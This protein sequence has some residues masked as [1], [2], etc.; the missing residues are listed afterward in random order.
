VEVIAPE[1]LSPNPAKHSL[2]FEM[3]R[4]ITIL[5]PLYPETEKY[6]GLFTTTQLSAQHAQDFTQALLCSVELWSI[7][8]NLKPA[9]FVEKRGNY[10]RD[11]AK[12]GIRTFK[13]G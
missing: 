7:K 13:I 12:I 3:S 10:S 8:C 6:R 9:K 1:F 2:H 5:G 4:F 11:T